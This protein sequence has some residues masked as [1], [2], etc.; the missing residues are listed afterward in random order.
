MHDFLILLKNNYN[1]LLGRVFGKKQR[2]S[3]VVATALLV[4][5]V[6]GVLAIYTL[7]A[8]SMFSGLGALHLEKVCIFH[9]IITTL[10]VLVIIGIMRSSANQKTN[11]SDF[12]LSLPL[13][14]GAIIASKT[15]N[16]Y[17]FDCFF[18]I[19][20]FLPYLVLYQIFAGI[21]LQ[22]LI[23]GILLILI[24]P[25]FSV[26][27]SHILD[28]VISRLFN[29][30]KLGGLLKSFVVI[31]IFVTIMAL[32]ITKTFTYGTASFDSLDAYF[33]DRPISNYVLQFLFS[34]NLGNILAVM[35]AC[36]LPFA[37]GMI[38]YSINY[39]KTFEQYSSSKT[40][41][42]FGDGKSELKMMYKKELYRYA[43][44]PAYLINTLIGAIVMLVLA[45]FICVLGTDGIVL[46]LGLSGVPKVY[47]VAILAMALGAMS[48]TAP[49]SASSVSLEGK[50]FW[51]LKSMPIN[52]KIVL[53]S[54]ALVHISII[55]P[56]IIVACTLISISLRLNF[57]QILMLFTLPTLVNLIVVFGGLLLN[58]WQANFDFDNETKVV[59]Q[60]L[61][62][63]LCM[64]FGMLLAI[65]PY[66]IYKLLPTF[67][68]YQVFAVSAGIL[69][70]VLGTLVALVFTVGVKMF[71]KL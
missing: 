11:D 14:K 6:L 32:M 54:K 61:P 18:A 67:T 8:Y 16:F 42:A 35:L 9:A 3:T 52:E 10:T 65:M 26:G 33:A 20:L 57:M 56:C 34:P 44:T 71:R 5:G 69:G 40:S 64:I 45:I 58:L 28:F 49:I 59:K 21:N 19:L 13:K 4:L 38:L 22:M 41:L 48:A 2:V 60:S 55:Q 68:A 31:L 36:I 37:L 17:I 1:L 43:T 30:F 51:I 62:V 66:G 39:G 29:R 53:L 63:L 27:I 46:Q 25:L 70:A 12:L 7:Q 23:L 15:L 24:L 50:Q 47:I